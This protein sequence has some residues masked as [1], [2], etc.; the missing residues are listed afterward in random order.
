MKQRLNE[1]EG[2]SGTPTELEEIKD[3]IAKMKEGFWQTRVL[4]FYKNSGIEMGV[5][6]ISNGF[7]ISKGYPSVGKDVFTE[8]MIPKEFRSQEEDSHGSNEKLKSVFAVFKMGENKSNKGKLRAFDDKENTHIKKYKREIEQRQKT[9]VGGFP[10]RLP[11]STRIYIVAKYKDNKQLVNGKPSDIVEGLGVHTYK[12]AQFGDVLRLPADTG[13]RDSQYVVNY[14]EDIGA[15]K[16]VKAVST[17]L[18]PAVLGSA[19]STA[20]TSTAGLMESIKASRAADSEYD[21]L[22]KLSEMY[23][24]KQ[25]IK[26]AKDILGGNRVTPLNR[27]SIVGVMRSQKFPQTLPLG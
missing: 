27:F 18:D 21:A 20:E 22:K 11:V 10:Y 8:K 9:E 17:G 15:L 12:I 2:G 6:T 23:Y 26:Q 3:A 25:V 1:A 14:Y 13:S 4:S 7:S 5:K 24:Y 19:F 16:K